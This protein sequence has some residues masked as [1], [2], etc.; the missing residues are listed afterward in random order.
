[1]YR[2]KKKYRI[3]YTGNQYFRPN[4]HEKRL[5]TAEIRSVNPKPCLEPKLWW[6]K[7]I[8][9]RRATYGTLYH[10]M[11]IIKSYKIK[12]QYIYICNIIYLYNQMNT[13]YLHIFDPSPSASIYPLRTMLSHAAP[14]GVQHKKKS[15]LQSLERA[16][17]EIGWWW[18]SR[19]FRW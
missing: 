1:M 13:Y 16:I 10:I 17:N 4:K 14:G 18:L 8:W 7:N 12:T 9:K 19:F 15:H 3:Y 11:T 6:R 2:C 5:G